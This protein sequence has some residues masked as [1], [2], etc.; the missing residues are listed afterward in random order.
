MLSKLC[1]PIMTDPISEQKSIR[2]YERKI[3]EQQMLSS[4]TVLVLLITWTFIFIYQLYRVLWKFEWIT[5]F[6]VRSPTNNITYSHSL[7][8]KVNIAQYLSRFIYLNKFNTSILFMF[9]LVKVTITFSKL[10]YL[11][12]LVSELRTFNYIK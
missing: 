5:P 8:T 4:R 11:E 3:N 7:K 12:I 2:R 9:G 6:M 10:F 1:S